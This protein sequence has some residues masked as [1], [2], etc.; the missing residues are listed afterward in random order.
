M[1]NK[2]LK[3]DGIEL[4]KLIDDN[5]VSLAFFDPQYRG[6]L[7]KL[8]YGNEGA[9]QIGRAQ[10]TQMSEETIIEFIKGISRTLKPSGYLMLW[11]DKFHLCE[12]SF[13]NW[14][15]NQPLKVV[16]LIAWDKLRMGYRSRR[17]SEYL[18]IIQKEPL[19]A[20]ATWVDHGIP[21]IW[22]EKIGTKTHPHQKP[23]SLQ[24]RLILAVTTDHDIVLD[25]CAGSFLVL[26][27][28]LET[29]RTFVG[30]DLEG[31]VELNLPAIT[32]VCATD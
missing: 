16:D 1:Y 21:D 30:G 11:V 23:I 5:S 32:M 15:A 24:K 26:N 19:K 18:I 2:K 28:C 8:K 13:R 25:P 4:L 6:V 10:L 14:M 3:I 7:D 17:R 12:G 20:K 22:S 29:G 31:E 27:A 9:R